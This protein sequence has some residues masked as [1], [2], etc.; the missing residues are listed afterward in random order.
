MKKKDNGSRISKN[1]MMKSSKKNG[2]V[3]DQT[4]V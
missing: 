4:N 2:S 3:K 1:N